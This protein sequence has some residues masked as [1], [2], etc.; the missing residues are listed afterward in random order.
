MQ[1]VFVY[2][3]S[4]YQF[5]NH[6]IFVFNS[7]VSLLNHIVDVVV[8]AAAKKDVDA[9]NDVGVVVDVD[10]IVVADVIVGVDAA[11]TL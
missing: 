10:A 6:Q 5:A 9:I 4:M 11:D 2:Q 1:L 8:D 7:H 3:I